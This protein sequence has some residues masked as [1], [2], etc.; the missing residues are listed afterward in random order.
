MLALVLCAAGAARRGGLPLAAERAP[1][2]QLELRR[3]SRRAL[4]R[5]SGSQ[6]LRP[7]RASV[8]RARLMRGREAPRFADRVRKGAVRQ[9]QGRPYGGLRASQR[10]QPRARFALVPVEARAGEELVRFRDRGRK[11]PLRAG[12]NGRLYGL[13]GLAR[14]RTST[15]RCATA[16]GRPFNPLVACTRFPTHARRSSRRSRWFRSRGEAS[17]N[18]SPV[19]FTKRF[20]LLKDARFVLD[21]TLR[22]DGVFGFGV[23]RVRQAGEGVLPDGAVLGGAPD[24]RRDGISRRETARSIIP[25][26]AISRSSTRIAAETPRGAI[27]RFTGKRAMRC[28]IARD[29]ASSRTMPGGPDALMLSVRPAPGGDRRARRGGERGPG[30]LSIRS[31]RRPEIDGGAEIPPACRGSKSTRS[32]PTEEPFRPR[33]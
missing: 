17:S 11:G 4:P 26:S 19:P 33:L 6:D 1:E 21:D 29:R 14:T 13:H 12:G 22:L 15:S 8:P 9:A 3:V 16:G 7:H 10:L 31:G 25:V 5:G 2:A 30:V 28:P 24:R 20:R 23:E 18:G 27:S 32:I